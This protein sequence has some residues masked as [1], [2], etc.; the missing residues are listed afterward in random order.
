MLSFAASIWCGLCGSA[1]MLAGFVSLYRMVRET[2]AKAWARF[3]LLGAA[4]ISGV[5]LVHY[6]AGSLEPMLYKALAESGFDMAGFP[7]LTAALTPW[8][9]PLNAAIILLV[10]SQLVVLV[11]GT[12]SGC[13]GLPKKTILLIPLAALVVGGGFS[14]LTLLF[15]LPGG[16]GGTESLL[17]GAMYLIPLLYWREGRRQVSLSRRST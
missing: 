15:G 17:E 8:Y 3:S 10:Y 14:L 9:L 12:V 1:L 4:G 13:F 6:L 11:Y 16:Y 5:L 2:C 7:A